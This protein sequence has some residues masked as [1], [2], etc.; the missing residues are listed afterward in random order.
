MAARAE[1]SPVRAALVV[2]AVLAVPLVVAAISMRRP[3]WF[4]ALDH[5]MTEVRVRDV[6]TGHSPLIGLPGRIGPIDEQG[7]HPGPM[8]FWL[9]AP[10][11][12]LLGS[13]AW[14]LQVSTLFLHLV[15]MVGA[16]V[17]AARRGSTLLVLAVG[18]VIAVLAAA[19]G[20]SALAEP[21]N[22]YLPLF[23]WVLFLVA[24]WAA[25][26]GDPPMLVVAA[27]AGSFCAQTHLPYLGPTLV[28]GLGAVVALVV[29]HRRD[30]ERRPLGPWLA[31]AAVIALVL[32]APPLIDQLGDDEGNLSKLAE[33][34]TDPPEE[35]VG[36]GTGVE[37]VLS[38]L[39]PFQLDDAGD[40]ARGS[41]VRTTADRTGSPVL[42]VVVLAGWLVTVVLAWRAR[43]RGP[44]VLHAVVAGGLAL[45]VLSASQI[46]G[47]M[48]RY[49]LLWVWAV[50][51][52]A[53]VA[54]VWTLADVLRDRAGRT[55]RVAPVALVVLVVAP[56]AVLTVRMLD[57]DPPGGAIS[58]GLALVAD[59]TAAALGDGTYVVT[60]ADSL[61][62]GSQGYGLVNELERR[63]VDVRVAPFARW[64]MTPHRAIE[65]D[66]ATAGVR[67]ATGDNIAAFR[68]QRPDAA[69]IA[70]GDPRTAAER[71][72]YER[73]HDDLVASMEA[74][75]FSAD[76][77]AL[78]DGNLFGVGLDP[79]LTDEQRAMVERMLDLGAPIAVFLVPAGDGS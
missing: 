37:A 68:E 20:P 63:G 26:S 29:Q 60:W 73:L 46:F 79:R 32:W 4:P 64:A 45:A 69:E 35:A 43:A 19:F 22:P 78:V 47:P 11:Y 5:A 7:S 55:A 54:A 2:A 21:W 56:V 15:A 72:E 48:W 25:V 10:V 52:L 6:G 24:I 67:L 3:T 31:A 9:L 18:A 17:V 12:R 49:L 34:L 13:S 42:G 40:I 58:E 44:L 14:S 33:H 75:G 77:I 66:D 30:P 76:D 39:D 8:S 51:A 36:W 70:S 62:I 27:V 28:L 74:D 1:V 71:A 65:E 61:Y 16:L 50:T 59:D 38:R 23:W 41:L 53:I 57:A